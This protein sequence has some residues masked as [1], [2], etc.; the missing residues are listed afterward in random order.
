MIRN[1][2][3]IALRNFWKQPAFSAINVLGLAIGISACL[4]IYLLVR[5]ELS[6]DT[7]HP[8]QK[9][10]YRVVSHNSFADEVFKN[11]GVSGALPAAMRQEVTG[12]A[13]VAP[14]HMFYV[15]Q[16][17]IPET[18]GKIKKLDL[19][20][21]DYSP[22]NFN[23]ILADQEYFAVFKYE[24]LVGNAKNALAEPYKVVLSEKQAQKY[25][26]AQPAANYFGRTLTYLDGQDTLTVTVS[27]VVRDWQQNTDFHFTDFVSLASAQ[28]PEWQN[29][30]GLQNWGSTSS[31][32]Q[33]LIKLAANTAPNQIKQ[34][35]QALINRHVEK[36]EYNANRAYL[37]QP[38]SDIH[39]NAEYGGDYVRLA[40]RPTLYA[41]IGVAVFLLLVAGI[42]FINLA[43]AQSVQRAKEIGVRK[44]LGSTR[45]SLV[46]QFLSETFVLTLAAVLL[47]VL[48]INPVLALLRSFLPT[49][50]HLPIFN[51]VILSFLAGITLLTTVLAGF[52]PAWVLSAMMPLSS[53]KGQNA[54]ATTRKA[55]LR[56]AL[57]VFQFTLSQVFILSALVV[58]SQIN[59]MRNQDMGFRQ[60]EIV[61][62]ELDWRDQSQNK[63]VLLNKI[64]QMPEVTQVSL[65]N[66]TPARS[67]ANT[68]VLKYYQGKKEISL[69]VHNKSGDENFINLYGIKL[70][71]GRNILP[72]DTLREILINETYA[73]TIG[74][75]DAGEAVGQY[76]LL[77]KL[78][79]PIVGVV[80]DFHAQ[81]LHNAIEPVFIGS[82]NKFARTISLK[83]AAPDKQT[84]SVK[85]TL[86]K[87]E[88]E[89]EALYPD[90]K[91]SYAFFD[92]TI[93]HFYDNEQKTATIVRLATTLAIFISCLGLIGLVA[94]TVTQ[95]TKEI[96]IRKVLGASVASIVSLLSKDFLK[97]VLL[98]NLIA[99]PLAAWA[100]HRWLQDFAYRAPLSW[101]LFAVAGILAIFIAWLA[102]GL[103]AV[104]AAIANP[105]N[106][107]RTE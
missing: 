43:T 40:H 22:A 83:I 32:S 12:L 69:N 85:A 59:F 37:L 16:V 65:S 82:E 81:S 4:V 31:S 96:G 106:S 21:A 27:G 51:P 84:A 45:V 28:N 107:L 88:K 35:F 86:A 98:A 18:K 3:K 10:I 38:L 15:Q 54:A 29:K 46:S 75:K 60:A 92:E 36:D 66:F 95:R 41:L 80:A 30:L 23:Y 42:N 33:L 8:D 53:L 77:D 14:F 78:K 48:L 63:F 62:F 71:A 64:R 72:S 26:G 97:L 19:R 24:W 6:Y 68:T 105:V 7:F 90:Q 13:H 47:A 70:L 34:Q 76:V 1:Y 99:W 67:G 94:F 93:A 61:T 2:F 100:M 49:G 104:K 17:H 20:S 25:F 91:F 9:Q 55:Y 89:Y 44:V 50:I 73:K 103:Q 87:I 5:F 101:W 102:V 57:I 58:G 74:F 79:L 39:F 52:Y 11:N 56:K